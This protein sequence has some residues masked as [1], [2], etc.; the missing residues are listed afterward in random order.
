MAAKMLKT[1]FKAYMYRNIL[2]DA[3]RFARR[4]FKNMHVDSDHWL[5]RVGLARY[6]PVR[7]SI[8]GIS[9]LLLGGVA[10]AVVALAFAPKPGN[11]LRSQMRDRAM[12]MFERGGA[13]GVTE[14]PIHA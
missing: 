8:G 4:N 12:K 2:G 11:E 5:H 14:T 13:M 3:R 7:S 10:G 6:T 1:M 9:L